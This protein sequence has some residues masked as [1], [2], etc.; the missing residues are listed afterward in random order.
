L[1]CGMTDWYFSAFVPSAI[2][3]VSATEFFVTKIRNTIP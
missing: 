2:A 1:I 3:I